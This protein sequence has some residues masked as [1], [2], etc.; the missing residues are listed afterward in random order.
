MTKELNANKTTVN[1][2][3]IAAWAGMIGSALFVAVFTLE[4]WLRPDYNPFSMYI[5][6]LS[7]GPRGWIQ[8]INFIVLGVFLLIFAWG[9]RAEFPTGKTARGGSIMLAI[10]AVL[11][12]V[13]GIFVMDPMD[14]PQD[15]MSVHGLIHG[16]AGG[17]V[18]VL[19][20]VTIFVYLRRFRV[21]PNWLA[22]QGWTVVLG[23]IEATAVIIFTIVSKSPT[24]FNTF[25]GWI[26]LIQRAALIPFMFWLFIFA[27][28]LHK[29]S[30]QA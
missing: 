21:E 6:A 12:I 15:Q 20:P 29:Q 13:S 17:I 4:G 30:K 24:L 3:Q 1:Q 14:T 16:I 18:F 19:M 25:A 22:V 2:R 8:V 7:L 11:F 28:H 23:I 5:S 26:G 10:L 27:L 9:I